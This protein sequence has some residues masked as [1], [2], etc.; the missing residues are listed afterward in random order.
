MVDIAAIKE[1]LKKYHVAPLKSLGQHFLVNDGAI[2]RIIHIAD[3]AKYDTILE[4]GPGIGLLTKELAKQAK[5]L[6]AVEIDKGFFAILRQE[7]KDY[8]QVAIIHAD[9]LTVP[10]FLPDEYL[11]VGNLPYN[12]S[13]PILERFLALDARPRRMIITVQ[14]E[15]AERMVAK[16]PRMNRLALLA[17]FHGTVRIVDHFPPH[18]FWPQP[19]VH[20]SLVRIDLLP[21][22]KLP[23]NSEGA[24]M[25][26]A[27]AKAA[28]GQQRKQLKNTLDFVDPRFAQKRP[29]HLSLS[30]WVQTV[31]YARQS[32]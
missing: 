7:L 18:Y 11:F 9:A 23:L 1:L 31:Q 8:P 10:L 12:A 16:P 15:F 27:M 30:D 32:S 4:V 17:Q 3:I 22:D 21:S 13:A 5:H 2:H 24:A 6:I 29:S 28:F 20:S 25:L 19:Q 26:A 14:R